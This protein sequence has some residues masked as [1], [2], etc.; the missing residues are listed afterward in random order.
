MKTSGL[1]QEGGI[2]VTGA[3]FERRPDNQCTKVEH[4]NSREAISNEDNQCKK[5][6]HVSNRKP[7]RMK[8]GN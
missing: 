8:I 3:R 4:M 1:S 2:W 5:P 6:G 7:F